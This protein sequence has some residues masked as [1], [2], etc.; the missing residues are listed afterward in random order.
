M[1]IGVVKELRRFPVKSMM[2]EEPESALVTQRG[3]AG[4]RSYAVFDPSS[5]RVA[6]AKVV[7]KWGPLFECSARFETEPGDDGVPAARITLPD[8]VDVSTDQ[9]DIHSLLSTLL[10]QEVKLLSAAEAGLKYQMAPPGTDPETP[11]PPMD[12]IPMVNPFFDIGS[13][14]ILA[15]G[16]LEH[17]QE[18]YPDG[19][20]D[21]RRFRPNLLIE[22]PS[23]ERGFLENAWVGK[24]LQIGDEVQARIISPT[25]RCVM[26]TLPQGDLPK[27]PGI[28][29]TA[30][31]HN[32]AN[33][34]AYGVV[35]RAGRVR[36]G[37]AVTLVE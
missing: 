13:L 33:V 31:K 1:Q 28:L 21:A 6:T 7:R 16:T 5:G 8:G 25:V 23:G 11:D 4:D 12:D 3:F 20:F 17:M 30:V 36:A 9:P 37:D 19:R 18:L 35:A 22:T 29:R 26:T 14:H 27:D 34:G 15:T 2:G 24:V 32:Q 10:G